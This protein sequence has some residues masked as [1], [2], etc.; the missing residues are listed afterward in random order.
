MPTSGITIKL[1]DNTAATIRPV[2]LSPRSTDSDD[3]ERVAPFT[4]SPLEDRRCL[5]SNQKSNAKLRDGS[6]KNKEA[7][8]KRTSKKI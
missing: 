7:T 3:E 5:S 2:L 8:T 1:Y 6:K 4:T